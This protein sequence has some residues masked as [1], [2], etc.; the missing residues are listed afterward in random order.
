MSQP[1]HKPQHRENT[2][3]F[4]TLMREEELG[5]VNEIHSNTTMS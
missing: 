3:S 1:S 5:Q 4:E 2:I